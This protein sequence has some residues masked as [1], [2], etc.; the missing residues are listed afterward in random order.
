MSDQDG[1]GGSLDALILVASFT[2]P[3]VWGPLALA[4]IGEYLTAGM[5]ASSSWLFVCGYESGLVD[6]AKGVV[7]VTGNGGE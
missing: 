5:L 4:A 1:A 2:V 6:E 7:F 3:L